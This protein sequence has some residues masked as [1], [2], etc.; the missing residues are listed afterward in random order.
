MR[1]GFFVGRVGQDAEVTYTP[2]GKAV[3][4]FSIAID[5]GK[6]KQGDKREATWI[7]AVLWE[8][9]AETLSPYIK[10]GSVVAV[11]GSVEAQAWVDKQ[12]GDARGKIVVTVDQFTFGGGGE[13]SDSGF[14]PRT[15]PP[16][17]VASE[18]ISD[19]DIPF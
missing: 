16:A 3:A 7:Q 4:K 6:D 13:K 15:P 17:P 8:K 1:Q 18:P 14:A 19:E 11:S 2:S 5:N 10:K 12:S 9:R